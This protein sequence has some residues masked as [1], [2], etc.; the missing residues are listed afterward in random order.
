[1]LPFRPGGFCATLRSRLALAASLVGWIGAVRRS[2]RCSGPPASLGPA[3]T[4][5]RQRGRRAPDV[6]RR[7]GRV[8]RADAVLAVHR[9]V[10]SRVTDGADLRPTPPWLPAATRRGM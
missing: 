7:V 6:G 5:R 9:A 8:R 3:E 2:G 10:P 4:T 1:M